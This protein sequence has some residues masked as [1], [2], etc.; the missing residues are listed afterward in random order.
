MK[1][2]IY[3]YVWVNIDSINLHHQEKPRRASFQKLLKLVSEAMRTI[4]WVDSGDYKESDENKAIDEV[5][6]FLTVD[7]KIIAKAHAY[8]ELVKYLNNF[9]EEFK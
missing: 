2:G 1:G 7:P 3:N 9:I 4:E 5:F 8:D 6:A